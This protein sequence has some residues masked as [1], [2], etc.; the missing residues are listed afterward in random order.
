[1]RY[2]TTQEAGDYIMHP[3]TVIE[4]TINSGQVIVHVGRNEQGQKF[5]FVN[6]CHENTWLQE[7]M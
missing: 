3:H 1:M 2:L 5:V 4:E 6:D 7:Y